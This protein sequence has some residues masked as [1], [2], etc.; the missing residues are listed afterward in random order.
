MIKVMLEKDF[1]Y[2]L[3][4]EIKYRFRAGIVVDGAVAEAAIAHGAARMPAKK[5]PAPQITKPARPQHE[6]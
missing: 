5:T 2:Y 6:G 1:D 4:A 3:S